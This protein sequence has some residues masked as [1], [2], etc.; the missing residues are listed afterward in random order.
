MPDL[1]ARNWF[2]A[3][4]IFYFIST[5]GTFYLSYITATRQL[6]ENG[7][8]A[9]LYWFL[10]FQYNGWFFFACAGLFVDYLQEKN[11]LPSSNNLV[12]WLFAVSCVPAYGLSVL[13][14]DLSTW[15]YVIICISAVVQFYAIVKFIL[16]FHN[17]RSAKVLQWGLLVKFLMLFVGFSL[18]L[19][20]ALQLGST[21]PIIAKFAFGFRP[22]VIAYLHLVLLAFT[23]LFLV[24]Y[25]YIN[26]TLHFGKWA[27]RGLFLLSIG[28]LL[29][30]FVLALQGIASLDYIP[31]PY[32]NEMLFAI[33]LLIFVSLILVNFAKANHSTDEV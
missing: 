17:D 2:I 7:Y 27:V 8:L 32:A 15:L 26:K 18:L 12:F 20:L 31:I 24:T 13:W 14:L 29:N 16:D 25:L 10:H 11:C 23:S 28:I 22:I 9:S 1:K 3:S 6:T 33:A 5:F 19:K 21:V 30:E 4:L